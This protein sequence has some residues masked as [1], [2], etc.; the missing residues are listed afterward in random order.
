MLLARR[1][2][3]RT[4]IVGGNDVL[5]VGALVE[6]QSKGL[7]VPRDISVVGFDN[8][9]FSMHSN[10]Q[11]TTIEVPVEKMGESA[12]RYILAPSNGEAVAQNNPV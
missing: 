8:L 5:A 2:P 1:K 12:A 3:S 11:F 10:P 4:A 7:V 9:E 6:C